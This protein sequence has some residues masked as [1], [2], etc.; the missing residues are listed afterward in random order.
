MALLVKKIRFK[1]I[2][3]MKQYYELKDEKSDKFWEINIK[4]IY[5]DSI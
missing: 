1:E 2:N 4:R 5:N 3:I